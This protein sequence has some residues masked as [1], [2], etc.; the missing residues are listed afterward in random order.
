[1][2][3]GGLLPLRDLARCVHSCPEYNVTIW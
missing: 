1:L 3:V 2:V